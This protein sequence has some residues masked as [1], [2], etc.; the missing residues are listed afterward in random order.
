MNDPAVEAHW[1]DHIVVD[2]RG[3]SVFTN[4]TP[5]CRYCDALSGRLAR[6]A[7]R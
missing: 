3:N 4:D 5:G 7:D 1:N 6:K 2:E